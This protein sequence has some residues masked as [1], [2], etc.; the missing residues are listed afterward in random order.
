MSNIKTVIFDIGRVMMGFE[1]MPFVNGLWGTEKAA[2]ITD[3][4]W[5]EGRWNELDR[6]EPEDKVLQSFID[7]DPE[8]EKEI[9]ETFARV[10]ESMTRKDYAIPWI[11]E[12]K[13]LGYQV[14][15]LSNYSYYLRALK[16][17]VLDFVPVMDGGIFS[18]NVHLTK[19]EREIYQK[20]CEMYSL[21]PEEC[22]FI[23]DN[24]DNIKAAEEFGMNT[25]LFKDFETSYPQVMSLLIEE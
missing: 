19:P 13:E 7:A 10:G 6:G 4:I 14:L 18:C 11:K 22:L 21:I 17:E 8:L 9:R 2:R 23:D 25:V 24:K 1:W 20:I 3:A 5:K 16:P 15:F 12:V